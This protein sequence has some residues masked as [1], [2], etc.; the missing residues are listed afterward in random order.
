MCS[1]YTVESHIT[2]LKEVLEGETVSISFQMLD[3]SNKAAHVLMTLSNGAGDV[4]AYHE[5]MLLHVKKTPDGPKPYPFGRYQ[6]A[7][8]VHVYT[9]DKELPR[10]KKAGTR[11]AIR[12][13]TADE[14]AEG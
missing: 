10:P 3:L 1:V 11:I 12:R 14:G 9:K 8:L 6:L 4:C 7:N 13:H 2:F 5:C